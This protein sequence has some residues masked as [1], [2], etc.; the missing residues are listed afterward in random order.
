MSKAWQRTKP[1][2]R[3]RGRKAVARR[4]AWLEAHPLCVHCEA[5]GRTSIALVVDH[6][7]PLAKQGP[8]DE[9]NLQSLCA[10]CH[11]IKT[12]KDLGRTYK[13]VIGIDG[14]PIPET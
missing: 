6:I 11:D 8:D 1:D 7:I 3:L 2:N 14:Y 4:R 13:P 5:K 9:S 12:A 10:T